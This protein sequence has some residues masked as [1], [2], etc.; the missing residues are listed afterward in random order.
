[1]I[2]RTQADPMATARKW[3]SEKC[4]VWRETDKWTRGTP[5]GRWVRGW[6]P[7]PV[8]ITF[9]QAP[10]SFVSMHPATLM[11]SLYNPFSSI[12]FLKCGGSSANASHWLIHMTGAVL[13]LLPFCTTLS[14][15]SPIVPPTSG[16]F[17]TWQVNVP[18]SVGCKFQI[19]METSLRSIFPSQVT[20]SLNR[21]AGSL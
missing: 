5:G 21:P 13:G 1:M 16:G 6:E 10:F 12:H 9:P 8:N 14:R 4:T 19:M 15:T 3:I 2:I 17:F 11:L 7:V 20:R 18:L